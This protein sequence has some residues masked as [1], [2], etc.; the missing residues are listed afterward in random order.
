M[1]FVVVTG[2]VLC[3][4]GATF[5]WQNLFSIIW[6]NFVWISVA[7]IIVLGGSVRLYEEL[8]I[9]WPNSWKPLVAAC[10]LIVMFSSLGYGGYR[11]Y[12]IATGIP[13]SLRGA[14]FE[15]LVTG[16]EPNAYGIE[17]TKPMRIQLGVNDS[18]IVFLDSPFEL[19]L[20]IRLAGNRITIAHS[21]S[22]RVMQ[23]FVASPD[24]QSLD[25]E[26]LFSGSAYV[27][28]GTLHRI[29]P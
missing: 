9:Y 12:R 16:S 14:T 26:C 2:S 27:E 17:I 24:H 6:S 8:R 4:L 11:W 21:V 29:G 10:A 7:L 22:T 3:W 1:F 28:H 23:S 25:Y 19:P 20:P 15:G 5:G 13:S 18:T